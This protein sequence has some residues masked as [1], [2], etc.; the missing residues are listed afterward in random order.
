[1]CSRQPPTAFTSLIGALVAV[2][3]MFS[4]LF[5]VGCC[6]TFVALVFVFATRVHFFA[7]LLLLIIQD[8]LLRGR[9]LFGEYLTCLPSFLGVAGGGPSA[10][11]AY[12]HIP[13]VAVVF[14][15]HFM[16]TCGATHAR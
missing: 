12:G 7:L 3:S 10:W 8:A 11:H 16:D 4:V 9:A 14:G 5:E 6:G 2:V 13:H 15:E 1:M